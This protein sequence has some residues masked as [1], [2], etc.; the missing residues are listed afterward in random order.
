MFSFTLLQ[1][2]DNRGCNFLYRSGSV[3]VPEL[4]ENI[5]TLLDILLTQGGGA[6][7]GLAPRHGVMH[8][9]IVD[10]GEVVTVAPDVI[11]QLSVRLQMEEDREGG[12]TE[13]GPSGRDATVLC[14][15]DL[16]VVRAD[17]EGEAVAELPGPGL[18]L[19]VLPGEEHHPV[20]PGRQETPRAQPRPRLPTLDTELV[21]GGNN[22]AL[23]HN[24]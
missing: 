11:E 21:R 6:V 9:A 2:L 19:L 3:V 5:Q 4:F 24:N 12:Q 14:E 16:L 8:A 18:R 22:S 15:H 17:G 20:T 10:L 7:H 23:K 1:F 13:A